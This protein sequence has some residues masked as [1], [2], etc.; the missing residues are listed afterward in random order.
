MNEICE[1]FRDFVVWK[2]RLTG[3]I[4]PKNLLCLDLSLVASLRDCNP[5]SSTVFSFSFLSLYNVRMRAVLL[6]M[7]LESFV[8]CCGSDLA[9]SIFVSMDWV[10]R[11]KRSS[12][13]IKRSDN[14]FLPLLQFRQLEI[15]SDVLGFENAYNV[16]TKVYT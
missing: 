5:E 4:L 8:N 1:L 12:R 16:Y 10:R 3:I 2:K 15:M 9:L 7:S 14:Y 11:V 13:M 6:L